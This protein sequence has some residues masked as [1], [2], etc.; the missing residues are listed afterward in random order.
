MDVFFESPN[1]DL[2]KR[3]R[4][5]T[6]PLQNGILGYML[7]SVLLLAGAGRHVL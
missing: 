6:F 1:V 3:Y 5:G 2:L 4:N 7:S